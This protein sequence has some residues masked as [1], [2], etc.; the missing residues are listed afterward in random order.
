MR[1]LGCV[2]ERL[3]QMLVLL[4]EI[5]CVQQGRAHT[6]SELQGTLWHSAQHE[7]RHVRLVGVG[8]AWLVLSGLVSCCNCAH[9]TTANP[10]QPQQQRHANVVV[11]QPH[12]SAHAA[13]PACTP[14]T[15]AV[16]R[17][18]ARPARP[19]HAAHWPHAVC[20]KGVH[21][22]WTGTHNCMWASIGTPFWGVKIVMSLP[23]MT[24]MKLGAAPAAAASGGNVAGGAYTASSNSVAPGGTQHPAPA[25]AGQAAVPG[26]ARATTHAHAHTGAAAPPASKVAAN[27][28]RLP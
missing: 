25:P 15:P 21:A 16:G 2:Q 28:A 12:N 19:H 27:A 13:L 17:T 8:G 11:M 1:C 9:K 5:G 7:H 24:I 10:E 6:Q 4:A 23:P 20:D 22:R 3:V 26:P 14:L 18:R